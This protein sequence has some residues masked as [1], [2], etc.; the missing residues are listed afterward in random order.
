VARRSRTDVLVVHAAATPPDLAVTAA[1]VDRWHRERGWD[2]IGYHFFIRRDGTLEKG[3]GLLARG[4][5]VKGHNDHTLG[6]CLAGGIDAQGNPDKNFTTAQYDALYRVLDVL[7][8]TF[9][10]AAVRGHKAFDGVHKACPCFDVGE[11]A[12]RQ[13]W[14]IER[15]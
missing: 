2:G 15:S 3:R 10:R 1:D 7:L 11:W 14:S 4:A 5:H 9:P 12:S 13:T 6:I 8:V